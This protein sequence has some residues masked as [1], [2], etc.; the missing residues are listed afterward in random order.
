MTK[1]LKMPTILKKTKQNKKQIGVGKLPKAGK[2][3]KL[4]VS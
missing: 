2:L 1:G 4:V 3:L